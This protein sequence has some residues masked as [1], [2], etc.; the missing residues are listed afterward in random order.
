MSAIALRFATAEDVGL[1]LQLIREL[2]VYEKV[3][4]AVVATEEDLRWHGFGPEPRFEA[5]LALVDGE[6]AGF[7]LF[8]P[9]SPL[10]AAGPGS[11]S[12]TFTSEN[13]RVGSASDGG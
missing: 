10:G 7:A 8:F 9:T 13:G 3:P 6:P 5:L 4:D 2:A 12:M 11:F 1:L